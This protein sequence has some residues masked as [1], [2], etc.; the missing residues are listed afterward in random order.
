MGKWYNEA[1]EK[2]EKKFCGSWTLQALSFYPST[3]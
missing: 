2:S 3:S 1:E